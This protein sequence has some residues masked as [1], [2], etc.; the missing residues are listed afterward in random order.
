LLSTERRIYLDILTP[1]NKIKK[2]SNVEVLYSSTLTPKSKLYLID[3]IEIPAI[4]GRD[5]LSIN[6]IDDFSLA[7]FDQNLHSWQYQDSIFLTPSKLFRNELFYSRTKGLLPGTWLDR[8]LNVDNLSILLPLNPILKKYFTS[9][10]LENS[11]R[12]DACNTLEGPEIRVTLS[13]KLSGFEKPIQYQVY[14]DFPLKVE[15]E[16]SKPFPILALW[17]NVPP[18]K[19][20]EYFVFIE[21][22]EDFGGVAFSIEPPTQGATQEIRKSGREKYQYWKCDRYPEILS[23][24]GQDGKFLGLLPLDIPKIQPGSGSTWT[25]GVEVKPSFTNV[26][27]RKGNSQPTR[28]NLQ[29]NLLQVTKR[30][31]SGV[32]REF[33]IPE[34]F[35]SEANNLPLRTM[36]TTRGWQEIQ[37]KIPEL[38]SQA[39]IYYSQQKPDYNNDYIETNIKFQQIEYLLPFLGE[40]LRLI[41]AQAAIEGVETIHWAVSYPSAFSKRAVYHYKHIWQYNLL[42]DLTKISGQF[43]DLADQDI[44]PKSIAFAQFFAN[45]LNCNLAHTTCIN[46]DDEASEISVWQDNQLVHQ[47]SVPY[48][49]RNVFHRILRDNLKFLDEVF[50]LSKAKSFK[51]FISNESNFNSALDFYLRYNADEILANGYVMNSYKTRNQEF[52]TLVAFAL[53]GLYHYLGLIQRGLNNAGSL[54]YKDRAS[55]VLIGGSSSSLL[56]WL[57]PYGRYTPNS[58]I[59]ELLQSILTQASGLGEPHDYTI[60]SNNPGDEV[61]CG[62][63]FPTDGESLIGWP[64]KNKDH[65]FLGEDCK[66]NGQIFTADQQLK[67]DENWKTI[68]YFRITSFSELERYIS[69]FNS[70][71]KD[72]KIEEIDPLRNFIDGELLTIN[73]SL[74]RLSRDSVTD[75]CLK[76]QGS[77]AEFEPEPPFLLTL[78]CF[79]GVLADQWSRLD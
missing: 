19:W 2:S 51:G 9:E 79:V 54:R 52:R 13:L 16:I 71:I 58:E 5:A 11:V 53:G 15:N 33:F 21:V 57:S 12:L 69:N 77:V 38:I 43:H 29:S 68:D 23:A 63:V 41:S 32:Y 72:K 36:L 48:R 44:R 56:H 62:L 4:M 35:Y 59:N 45:I 6:V 65:L 64:Q 10:D 73:E 14:K 37:G 60:F 20:R 50:G 24:I 39:R 31:E 1:I 66:I 47:V 46:L 74:R 3:S 17:P 61:S 8:K 49:G 26:H 78:R 55:S 22:T 18:G 42:K 40:L 28:L 34:F 25:V 67:I 76:K 7:D 27:I 70:I 75:A 30:I